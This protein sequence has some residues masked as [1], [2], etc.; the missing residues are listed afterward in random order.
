M[1]RQILIS[2]RWW[3]SDIEEIDSKH[4]EALEET[5]QD[6]IFKMMPD[7]FT[8]GQLNGNIRMHDT[9]PEDG[10]HYE[11]WWEAS[12]ENTIQ[13]AKGSE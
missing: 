6:Q 10:I 3:N 7:G 5:A 11:G 4:M 13:K 9:D 12:L 1:E 8:S 2:Y